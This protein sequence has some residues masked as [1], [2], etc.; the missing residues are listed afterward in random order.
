MRSLLIAILVTVPAAAR[1]NF[2]DVFDIGTAIGKVGAVAATTNGGIA[3]YYNPA[4]LAFR[5]STQLRI[6]GEMAHSELRVRHQRVEILRPFGVLIEAATPVPLV[7]WLRDKLAVGVAMHVIP[8]TALLVDGPTL[9]EAFLPYYE[10]RTSGSWRSRR[11]RFAHCRT[12]PSAS[13]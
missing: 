13:A 8:D 5:E 9:G 1:A 7:G 10:N 4:G 3:A 2:A 12:S 6:G 11:W